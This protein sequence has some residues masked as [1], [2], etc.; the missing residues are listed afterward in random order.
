MP[1]FK[2]LLTASLIAASLGSWSNPRMDYDLDDDGLIE[3]N[4]LADLDDIRNNISSEKPSEILGHT[5]Y[6]SS[7]GCPESGCYGY[8]LTTDLN[9][10]SNGNDA[11]DDGDL[12][13]NDGLGWNPIGSFSV[14][15]NAEFNGNGFAISNLVMRRPGEAFSGFIAYSEYGYIHDFSISA[16]M[17]T[18]AESGGVLAYGWNTR[19]E[20]I[21]ADIVIA[22]EATTE[23]CSSKC[24]PERVGGIVGGADESTFK[25]LVIKAHVTGLDRL[26][27]L[28]G[29][30]NDSEINEVALQITLEGNDLLGGLVGS[31]N[32]NNIDSIVVFADIEGDANVAGLIG[33]TSGGSGSTI[34]NILVSGSV[35]PGVN[36]DQYARGGALIG[37]AITADLISH[38][39]SLV[40]LPEDINEAHLIGAL[41]GKAERPSFSDV[42]WANDLAFRSRAYNGPDFRNPEQ[43]WDLIDLQCASDSNNCN[44]LLLTTFPDELNSLGNSIWDFELDTEAPSMVLPMGKFSDADGNGL[45]DNWPDKIAPASFHATPASSSS[46]GTIQYWLF[47]MLISVVFRRHT[48]NK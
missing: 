27:G 45:V 37:S 41:I 2:G 6:E 7:D 11:F 29:V 35:T 16:H 4:D 22:G 19:L 48:S 40:R 43:S 24:V 38:V 47:L 14:K 15:F 44:G 5:L 26:G 17:I 13:W 1:L 18:G 28:G 10:D 30:I 31:I 8:E 33:G 34:N 20:R 32:S 36:L 21:Y 42:Y 3:I 9:L 25:Q 39:I 23:P 46:G 12:F